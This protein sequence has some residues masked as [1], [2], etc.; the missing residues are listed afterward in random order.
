MAEGNR[1][2][3]RS[4][5]RQSQK[6]KARV[7]EKRGELIETVPSLSGKMVVVGVAVELAERT[8]PRDVSS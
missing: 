5:N 7:G 4:K 3:Y 2:E 6:K 1:N 8:E